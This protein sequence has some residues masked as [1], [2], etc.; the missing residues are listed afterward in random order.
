MIPCQEQPPSVS[1]VKYQSTFHG[2]VRLY[3]LL[4]FIHLGPGAAPFPH[5]R[6]L[7]TLFYL[8]KKDFHLS[9]IEPL[10][11][12]FLAAQTYKVLGILFQGFTLMGKHE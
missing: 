5:M 11:W 10:L 3:A 4:F 12:L 9:E 7:L 2:W 1:F 8:G 6:W